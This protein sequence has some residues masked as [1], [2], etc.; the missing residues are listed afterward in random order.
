MYV[1]AVLLVEHATVVLDHVERVLR[2]HLVD[3]LGEEAVQVLLGGDAHVLRSSSRHRM[4]V[5]H[6]AQLVQHAAVLLRLRHELHAV[7]V[8]RF[9]AEQVAFQFEVLLESAREIARALLRALHHTLVQVR[10]AL[11]QNHEGGTRQSLLLGLQVE[12]VLALREAQR[13]QLEV[14][15]KDKEYGLKNARLEILARLQR[16]ETRRVLVAEFAEV[17][18]GAAKILDTRGDALQCQLLHLDMTPICAYPR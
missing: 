2:L 3:V 6:P 1:N 18:G 5:D 9:D 12:H 4:Y 8:Q 7:V 11:L 14:T 13:F 17:Q 15:R 16:F 10:R